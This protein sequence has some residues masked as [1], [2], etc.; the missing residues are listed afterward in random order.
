MILDSTLGPREG[1]LAHIRKAFTVATENC[2]CYQVEMPM[3]SIGRHN[4]PEQRAQVPK[5]KTCQAAVSCPQCDHP[6][7]YSYFFSH[8][9]F[10]SL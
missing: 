5:A 1:I 9:A 4:S 7:P 3:V 2:K 10:F 6:V 8:I